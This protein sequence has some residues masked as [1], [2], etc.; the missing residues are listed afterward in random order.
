MITCTFAGHRD[1]FNES[2]RYL[3]DDAIES[4]IKKDDTF[5]FYSG[6]MGDFDKM[7]ESSVRVAQKRHPELNIKLVLVLPYMIK[8]LN[9]EKDYYEKLFD[10]I[11]I[12]A[13][14]A[15]V[16]YKS[17]ITKRNRWIIQRSDYLISYVHKNFGGAFTTLKYAEKLNKNIIYLPPTVI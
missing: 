7:C 13:E 12:P 15:E 17:A 9:T 10:N 2:I 5:L 14:L 6:N 16:H 8:K 4:I 1:I 11:I 3:I